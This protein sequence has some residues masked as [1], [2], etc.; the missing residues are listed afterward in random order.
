MARV[1]LKSEEE[2]FSSNQYQDQP[3][4]RFNAV[5]KNKNNEDREDE[6]SSQDQGAQGSRNNN[7]R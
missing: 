6:E 1:S 5:S 4:R 2:A 3:K 7:E